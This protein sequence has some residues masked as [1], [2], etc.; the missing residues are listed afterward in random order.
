MSK[1]KDLTKVE[2]NTGIDTVNSNH[3][4]DGYTKQRCYYII[5]NRG[6][7]FGKPSIFG[8]GQNSNQNYFKLTFRIDNFKKIP[9]NNSVIIHLEI[10]PFPS[11]WEFSGN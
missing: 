2:M 10:V 1:T 8:G 6:A 4:V 5:L 11:R 7:T 3:R 9:E